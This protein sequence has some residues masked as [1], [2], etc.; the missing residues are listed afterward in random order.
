MVQTALVVAPKTL[1]GW[2]ADVVLV[3]M[4]VV[5][6]VAFGFCSDVPVSFSTLS[7]G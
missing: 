2:S 6:V 7:L 3:V 4:E 5:E 1:S